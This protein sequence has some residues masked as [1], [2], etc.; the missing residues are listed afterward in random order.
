MLDLEIRG[1]MFPT[2]YVELD[3]D[4]SYE[5]MLEFC[6]DICNDYLGEGAWY[7]TTYDTCDSVGVPDF[8]F[9]RL[10]DEHVMLTA[11]AERCESLTWHGNYDGYKEDGTPNKCYPRKTDCFG[12]KICPEIMRWEDC[13]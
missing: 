9:V 2:S 7:V 11:D 10:A 3:K 13:H 12:N 1:I 5:E 4:F 6:A 8:Y